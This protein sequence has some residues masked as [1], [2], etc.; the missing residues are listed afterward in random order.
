MTLCCWNHQWSIQSR[1][2]Q[3]DRDELQIVGCSMGGLVTRY[4]LT[5][6]E[7]NGVDHNTRTFISFDSPQKG[8]N[9][10]LGMQALFRFL[11]KHE[12][13]FK[14]YYKKLSSMAAKQMLLLQIDDKE[15][16]ARQAFFKNLSELGNFPIDLRKVAISNGSGH[17]KGQDLPPEAKV[18][19]F[20]IEGLG[21]FKNYTGSVWSLPSVNSGFEWPVLET[22]KK[23]IGF[24]DSSATH[25]V[26]HIPA[27]YDSVPGG[28][29]NLAERV[30]DGMRKK[31]DWYVS[32]QPDVYYQ[33][34]CFIPTTSAL[35]IDT[36][37]YYLNVAAQKDLPRVTPFNKAY[38]QTYNEPHLAISRVT[39]NR[40]LEELAAIDKEVCDEIVVTSRNDIQV[41]T[42]TI[43]VAGG[44][45]GYLVENGG[46]VEF[47]A[48]TQIKLRP[49][50]WAKPGSRVR[51][52]L[53]Q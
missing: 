35:A 5:D 32:L 38:F 37:D 40:F 27:P 51:T 36:S 46:D 6:M 20:S 1:T 29:L 30:G 2:I 33:N 15:F 21:F 45:C 10:I 19:S 4:A 44:D 26:H 52:V 14:H 34:Y 49:G 48:G 28:M 18:F 12:D 23:S 42:K 41:A 11:Q 50:F 53:V 13:A 16:A 39:A 9:A 8:A 31:N 3:D 47:R 43:T 17:G 7:Y 24:D 25:Y 22:D